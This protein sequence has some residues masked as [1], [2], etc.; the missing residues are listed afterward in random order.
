GGDGGDGG[1]KSSPVSESSSPVSPSRPKSSIP[2]VELIVRDTGKG[3]SAEFLPYVFERFLQADGSVTKSYGGLG[4]GLAI[5][6]HLVELHGGT[7]SAQSDGEG[8]GATFIVRLP[9]KQGIRDRDLEILPIAS[10]SVSSE[11]EQPPSQLSG[12]QVLV[13][14]DDADARQFLGT[15]LE[16][17]GVTAIAVRS[18]AEAI[19]VLERWQ[20]D[21]LVS[22]IGMPL[23]DGYSLIRKVRAKE[24]SQRQHLPA[25][26]LTAYAR[27][28]DR[29]QALAAGYDEYIAKP[30]DPEQLL[31]ALVNL[32]NIFK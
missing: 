1:V 12:L 20:P 15:L 31:G 16:E 32:V 25:V 9:L 8:Q 17:Y 28:Q 30:V 6:R 14:E 3:I 27:E 5:V 2:Y 4:L 22:D 19:A 21:I 13:V 23:E 24:T 29:V 10:S 18:V 26:A 7:V 11:N